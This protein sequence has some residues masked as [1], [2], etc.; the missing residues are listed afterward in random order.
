VLFFTILFSSY[1]RETVDS[2]LDGLNEVTPKNNV[3]ADN[4]STKTSIA[5]RATLASQDAQ[6]CV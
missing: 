1:T 6:V 4:S 2:G 3:D 5:E